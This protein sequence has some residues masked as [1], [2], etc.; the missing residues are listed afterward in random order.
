LRKCLCHHQ[1]RGLHLLLRY[2]LAG[3]LKF[4]DTAAKVLETAKRLTTKVRWVEQCALET[5]RFVA[6]VAGVHGRTLR[7]V[8]AAVDA[9]N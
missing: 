7:A 6:G 8:L 3:F 1:L 5:H 2:N 9:R 4:L